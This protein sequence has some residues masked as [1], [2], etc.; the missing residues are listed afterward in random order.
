MNSRMSCVPRV[1]PSHFAIRVFG[2]L[3]LTDGSG[4][5][6]AVPIGRQRA[7]LERL[8]LSPNRPVK[9]DAVRAAC[10]PEGQ[11]ERAATALKVTIG[12]LRT[13]L[14]QIDGVELHADE[15]S[16]RLE[17]CPNQ[18]DLLAF[19]RLAVHDD[20][21]EALDLLAT[22]APFADF[23]DSDVRRAARR[24]I[25]ATG[26]RLSRSAQPLFEDTVPP[27]APIVY[28]I[29][30]PDDVAALVA[31]LGLGEDTQRVG[32]DALRRLLGEPD[33]PEPAPTGLRFGLSE[34]ESMIS[35]MLCSHMTLREISRQLYISIN[36][37]KSHTR[38]IYRKLGVSSRS[39]AAELLGSAGGRGRSG[40]VRRVS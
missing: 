5:D 40:S 26:A 6:V 4:G 3:R 37:T 7:V 14:R 36:T 25:G 30:A 11:P 12:R 22:G 38:S 29:V 35:K 23:A 21:D 8:L 15:Q 19:E 39:E 2:P 16:C 31:Q 32:E 28:V 24:R 9:L 10:W 1:A 33:R 13:V 18:M 34:R 17:V 27:V 20:A